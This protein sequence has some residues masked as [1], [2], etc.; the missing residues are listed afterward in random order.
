MHLVSVNATAVNGVCVLL[1]RPRVWWT[2]VGLSAN[3]KFQTLYRQCCSCLDTF[4]FFFSTH[5]FP[6]A[7][8]MIVELRS[9]IT[10]QKKVLLSKW[11]CFREGEDRA[12][13][14]S[15]CC[16]SLT[17][18]LQTQS[19]PP[20]LYQDCPLSLARGR[21]TSQMQNSLFIELGRAC[22]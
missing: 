19:A 5:F 15:H 16:G 17:V 6:M 9:G 20:K 12:Q 3:R 4:F 18:P 21:P 22:D 2:H 7:R 10:P 13:S 11:P 14:N 1:H 8:C